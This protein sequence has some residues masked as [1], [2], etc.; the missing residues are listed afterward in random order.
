MGLE[1][2]CI[3]FK[4]EFLSVHNLDLS[5]RKRVHLSH[6]LNLCKLNVVTILELLIPM[7]IDCNDTRISL[8]Y[9]THINLVSFLSIFI[10]DDKIMAIVKKGKA[11]RT[12]GL[13]K[14]KPYVLWA[15]KLIYLN[16]LLNTG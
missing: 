2:S 1:S 12:I 11:L 9:S 15:D 8:S 13:W 5:G 7:I 4:F 16:Y 3:N 14:D 6:T 10:I